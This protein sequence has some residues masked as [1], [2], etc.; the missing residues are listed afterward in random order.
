[1]QPYRLIPKFLFI[2][3][4]S[5]PF[6][7]LPI[8]HQ[9]F[10]TPS[11]EGVGCI[12]STGI[13]VEN[14][15]FFSRQDSYYTHGTY[16][17]TIG[18]DGRFSP[19][20]LFLDGNDERECAGWFAGQMIYTPEDL[21]RR[22]AYP[23]DVPYSS[24][25]YIGNEYRKELDHGLFS[26]QFLIGGTGSWTHGDEIQKKAHN[27]AIGTEPQGWDTQI[28][29]TTVINTT[30]VYDHTLLEGDP[31]IVE[32][33]T[34]GSLGNLETGM[35]GG[36]RIRTDKKE[37]GLY[38][39]LML[40]SQ[41]YN[42]ILQGPDPSD[43][44]IY[45]EDATTRF[46]G[47]YSA[48][49]N[50]N[51]YLTDSEVA[52]GYELL[53]NGENTIPRDVRFAFFR[54]VNSSSSMDTSDQLMVFNILFN[55]EGYS[56]DLFKKGLIAHYISDNRNGTISTGSMILLYYSLNAHK[57]RGIPMGFKYVAY[58][59]YTGSDYATSPEGLAAFYYTF[60]QTKTRDSEV[61]GLEPVPFYGELTMG[62]E[63]SLG[64]FR[65]HIGMVFRSSPFDSVT[66]HEDI[67]RWFRVGV[68]L[69]L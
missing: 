40:K 44:R 64:P 15:T 10:A 16:L 5:L 48:A 43:T 39:Q 51:P 63:E 52:L 41:L 1:M 56:S 59:M 21:D 32:G 24:V 12:D 55:G 7:L 30:V 66:N 29:S 61:W 47:Y 17:Y 18:K 46:A 19:F 45:N 67:Y 49:L 37:K 11:Q 28:P 50:G 62:Y 69:D 54:E 23:G 27:W 57:F 22:E 34:E 31:F 35:A 65:F 36:F 38:M 33:I 3:R 42:G 60:L 20:S 68:S 58:E 14:D 25:L 8:P 2:F 4:L 53:V 26:F 6:A 9:V 13:V